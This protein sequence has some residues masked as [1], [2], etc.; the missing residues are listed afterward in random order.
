MK[1]YLRKDKDEFIKRAI[2][3]Y[4]NKF[5]YNLNNFT[6]LCGNKIEIICPVH[7][8]FEQKPRI[9][10]LPNCKT[11]CKKC[12]RESSNKNRTY[13][14]DEIISKF[15]EIYNFRYTYPESNR[16]TYNNK[17]SKVDII[18]KEHGKFSKLPVH[19]LRGQGCYKCKRQESL[20]DGL[21]RKSVV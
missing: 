14:Y 2:E 6:G 8:I 12:G 13:T 4:G 17:N 19:H 21:D 15:N 16:I 20:N 10:L 1:E 18:C 5:S 7:G 9:F 3:K 11:G